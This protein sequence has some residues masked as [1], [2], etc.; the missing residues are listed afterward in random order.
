MNSK[1][2]SIRK[3][4]RLT[5]AWVPTGDIQTPLACV[6]VEAETARTASARSSA[7]NDEL[8]GQ[9]LCA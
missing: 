6:W 1:L 3:T 2:L 7:S 5:C 4:G 9:R 8:G